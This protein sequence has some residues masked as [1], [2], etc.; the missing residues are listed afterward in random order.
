MRALHAAALRARRALTRDELRVP[1]QT[2]GGV[3]LAYAAASFLDAEDASWSVFSALFVVQASIG[4]TVG[5]ALFRMAGALLGAAIAVLLVVF[6]GEGGWQGFVA[7]FIGV[8]GMSLITVRWPSMAYGLVTV[9][10]IIV[11]PGFY[12]VEDAF[13]KVFAI[14]I[15][16]SCGMIAAV[17]VFPL[18][19]RRSGQTH[20]AR[21]LRYCGAFLVQRTAW[22]VGDKSSKEKRLDLLITSALEKARDMSQQAHIEQKAPGSHSVIFPNMLLTDVERFRATLIL[23]DRFSDTPISEALRQHNKPHLR[24]MAVAGCAQLRRL[25]DAMVAGQRCPDMDDVWS[26][27]KLFSEEAARTMQDTQVD[28]DDK[29]ELMSLKRA[30]YAVFSNMNELTRQLN[31]CIDGEPRAE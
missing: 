16:S 20:L 17:A 6:I 8:V 9:T 23:V 25:A 2:A 14:A 26:H 19:A 22:L 27:Y 10:I 29:E 11:A 5:S 31:H 30:Y 7:L 13:K 21:A 18:S 1:V 15:G 12:V 4:G 24:D 3:L 28:A